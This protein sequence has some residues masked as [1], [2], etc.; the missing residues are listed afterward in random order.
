MI[1]RILSGIGGLA[2]LAYGGYG[3]V[4]AVSS[5]SL[6]MYLA[7]GGSDTVQILGREVR[8]S[9]RLFV[10]LVYVFVLALIAGGGWLCNFA[11]RGRGDHVG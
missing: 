7:Q 5:P 4:L 1:L 2:M 8:M 9:T 6:R 3:I 11:F 10:V